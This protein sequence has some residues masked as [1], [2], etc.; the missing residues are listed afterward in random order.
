[1]SDHN[2]IIVLGAGKALQFEAKAG[3]A[4]ISP[5][6]IVEEASNGTFLRCNANGSDAIPLIAIENSINGKT[7]N[8]AYSNG[9]TVYA[10][11][12]VPGMIV[13]AKLAANAAAIVKGDFLTYDG[14]GG[15]KKAVAFSQAGTTP[16]AVTPASVNRFQALETIN[17]SA[18]GSAVFILAQAI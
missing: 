5:G 1:M 8:D 4:G 9:E 18:N 3:E 12:L 13:Q 17:N 7:K 14:D 6:H 11:A 2:S 16:F 10:R 15:L